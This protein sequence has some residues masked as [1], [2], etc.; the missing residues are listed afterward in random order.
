MMTFVRLDAQSLSSVIIIVFIAIVLER[1]VTIHSVARAADHWSHALF[2]ASK[3]HC[4][5]DLVL[6]GQDVLL[7]GYL[8]EKGAYKYWFNFSEYHIPHIVFISL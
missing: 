8:H 4:G 3:I 6:N 5:S 7:I 2:K 1:A